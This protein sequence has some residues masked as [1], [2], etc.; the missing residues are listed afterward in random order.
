MTPLT[1]KQI[2]GLKAQ[3]HHLEPRV[4]IGKAGLTEALVAEV[5]SALGKHRLIKVEFAARKDEKKILAPEL[6]R[7]CNVHLV[8]LIGNRAI[9]YLCPACDS[10]A[11]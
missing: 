5:L 11:P 6:A 9:L 3:A 4:R 7:L 8:A 1:K 2:A 10:A